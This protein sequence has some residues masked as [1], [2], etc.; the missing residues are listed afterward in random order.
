[1]S[2]ATAVGFRMCPNAKWLLFFFFFNAS[3]VNTGGEIR[4]ITSRPC[5]AAAG[6]MLNRTSVT[7]VLTTP[8]VFRLQRCR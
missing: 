7:Q 1:M 8:L 5:Q 3:S 6:V 4:L 2:R